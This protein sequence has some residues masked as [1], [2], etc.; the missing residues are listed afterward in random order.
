MITTGKAEFASVIWP[1][2]T[3]ADDQV[4]LAA[5]R[6]ADRFRPGVLGEDAPRRL[7][8]LPDEVRRTVLGEITF[9]SGM[10]GMELAAELAKVDPDPKVQFSVVEALQFRGSDRLVRDVLRVANP[11]VW[12]SLV[13]RGYVGEMADHEVAER[14]RNEV[15]TAIAKELDPSRRL[16]L[17]LH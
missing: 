5:L 11:A 4:Y 13:E 3:S 10:D 7:T 16:R 15:Q 6:A 8:A 1:L 2:I 14:L 9:Q 12:S 17:L